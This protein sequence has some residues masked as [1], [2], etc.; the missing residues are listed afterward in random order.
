[1]HRIRDPNF[2]KAHSAAQRALGDYSAAH[3]AR[4]RVWRHRPRRQRRPTHSSG[5]LREVFITGCTGHTTML[6][7]L[8]SKRSAP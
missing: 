8:E 6:D 1:M 4:L 3:R 5:I 2:F 7:L